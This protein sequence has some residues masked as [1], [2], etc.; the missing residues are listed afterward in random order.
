MLGLNAAAIQKGA[1][2]H[3]AIVGVE[4]LEDTGRHE[5]EIPLIALFSF[6]EP[7]L[8]GANVSKFDIAIT[9]EEIARNFPSITLPL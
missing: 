4:S 1:P 8:Y 2:R 5:A 9:F 3:H 6:A 7:A